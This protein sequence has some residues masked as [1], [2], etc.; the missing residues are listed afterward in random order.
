MLGLLDN[1]LFFLSL[2]VFIVAVVVS[3]GWPIE[4]DRVPPPQCFWFLRGFT[5]GIYL[6]SAIDS[7]ALRVIKILPQG[8]YTGENKKINQQDKEKGKL[9]RRGF[10]CNWYTRKAWP[11]G[12]NHAYALFCFLCLLFKTSGTDM[13]WTGAGV[14]DMK[15]YSEKI[16]KHE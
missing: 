7:D 9:Y 14:T 13:A 5:T 11:A 12:C 10:S 1:G 6:I 8:R 2:R 4:S 16:K 3:G 15:H